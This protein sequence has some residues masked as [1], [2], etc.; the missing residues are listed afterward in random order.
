MQVFTS[1]L[2]LYCHSLEILN[3]FLINGLTF[4]FA[5]GATSYVDSLN[6]ELKYNSIYQSTGLGCITEKKGVDDYSK[7]VWPE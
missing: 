7:G 6:C 5:L 1:D 4:S 2:M 3:S